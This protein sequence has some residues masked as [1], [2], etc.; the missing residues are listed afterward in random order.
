[1]N[2]VDSSPPLDIIIPVRNGGEP[3][4]GTLRALAASEDQNYRLLISDNH[5]TDASPWKSALSAFRTGQVVQLRPP[6]PLGRVEHWTWAAQQAKADFCKL[7]LV[8]DRFPLD[9]LSIIRRA[10]TTNADLIY[11]PYMILG[12]GNTFDEELRALTL[13]DALTPL[14]NA[15]YLARC[16]IE[17][18][19]IGPLSAI[20][21]RTNALHKVLPFDASHGW[22]ADW[23]L[24]TRI[25]QNGT[26]LRVEG[27][28]CILDRTIARVSSSFKGVLNGI[29]EERVYQRELLGKKPASLVTQY[30]EAWRPLSALI[31]RH[32]LP[33]SISRPLLEQGRKLRQA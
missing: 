4:I 10:F 28:Y 22:T 24:Y 30:I 6:E 3:L 29:F 32:Y 1:M 19:P 23:R 33:E 21:F 20:T 15:D 25:M 11:T 8:G 13:R 31:A 16:A 17:M 18:N 2:A 12:R 9:H 27:T 5:S 7:L 14:S 26:A